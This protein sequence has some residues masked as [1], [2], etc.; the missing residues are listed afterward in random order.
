MNNKF[1]EDLETKKY[2]AMVEP[3]IIK[4][5]KLFEDADIKKAITE[6]ISVKE[7]EDRLALEG[8]KTHI[9]KGESACI[10]L[11]KEIDADLLTICDIYGVN[12]NLFL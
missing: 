5:D 7:V 8:M 12:R 6:W 3:V 2:V 9:D 4:L 10:V 11:C 1:N